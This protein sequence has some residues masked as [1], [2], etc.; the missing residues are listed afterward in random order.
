MVKAVTGGVTGVLDVPSYE[1]DSREAM[2]FLPRVNPLAG[3]AMVLGLIFATDL[4]ME[5]AV[6]VLAG[7]LFVFLMLAALFDLW[8]SP[9]R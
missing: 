3:L 4:G 6:Y 5:W 1:T 8:E 2:F 7:V 9:K